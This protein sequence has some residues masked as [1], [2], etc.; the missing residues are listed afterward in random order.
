[1]LLRCAFGRRMVEGEGEW[2]GVPYVLRSSFLLLVKELRRV[3][4]RLTTLEAAG[5]AK[6]TIEV[7]SQR[8][9]QT[10]ADSDENDNCQQQQPTSYKDGEIRTRV[11]GVE[12]TCR[13][14]MDRVVVVE[15]ALQQ[16]KQAA[17]RR[18]GVC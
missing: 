1:M 3:N 6:K 7:D 12:T 11:L 18:E 4:A 13:H 5:V 15:Q 16:V 10:S 2:R 9:K 17:Q 8:V 14:A